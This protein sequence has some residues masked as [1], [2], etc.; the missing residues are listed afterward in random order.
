MHMILP[1]RC[2]INF[3]ARGT[4][5]RMNTYELVLASGSPRRKTLLE[6]AGYTFRIVISD[7]DEDMSSQMS[8][9]EMATRN[10]TLKA[11]AVIEQCSIHELAIGA[12][13]V[14]AIDGVI[15]GKPSNEND[16]RKMLKALSGRTHQ[17]ITG[18]CIAG[19][20]TM[21]QFFETTNVTFKKLGDAEISAY[22]ATGE[23]LDKAGAYGIQGKGGALVDH[24]DG[25]Y[26][27]VVGLPMAKLSHRLASLGI[28]ANA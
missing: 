25:D 20:T 2:D 18:V 7:A 12:D 14:V 15:F 6:E 4:L 26:D 8:P 28:T 10:A 24:I 13:T 5:A 21:Q 19:K 3:A 22:I 11:Q 1:H 27:N 23:P 17:V 9:A 16:A